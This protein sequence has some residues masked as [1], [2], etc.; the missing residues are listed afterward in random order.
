MG[1]RI[2][3]E[4]SRLMACLVASFVTLLLPDTAIAGQPETAPV[5][6]QRLPAWEPGTLDIHHIDT[7]VGNA[8]FVMA[9]DGT[10]M[11]I[12]CGA[13]RGGPPAST[14]LRP[15]ESRSVGAWVS[16]YVLR[17]A[18]PAN[19]STLDYI[20]AT[21]VHPD[22][23]GSPIAGDPVSADGYVLTG[24]SEVDSLVPSRT[25]IDR[26]FPLYGPIG[27]INAPFASNHLAWLQSR[28]KSGKAVEAVKVGS[29]TQLRPRTNGSFVARFIAGNGRVWTGQGEQSKDLLAPA[30]TWTEESRPDEN[31][32]SI[33]LLLE[34]GGFRYFTGG[35][36]AADTHDGAFPWLDIETPVAAAAGHV[37]VATA[38]HHGYFDANWAGFVRELD[39]DAYVVQGW[40]ATHP[41]PASL[42]RLLNAWRGR[43]TKDVFVTRLDAA[44]EAVNGR[45][46]SQLKSRQGNVVVRVHADGSYRVF[47]TDSRDE[48]DVLTYVGPLRRARS[49]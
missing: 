21:H 48:R 27:T 29:A 7:G 23:V 30:S 38:N 46:L 37:D 13:T 28:L 35:D 17:Q 22:H 41:A 3:R 39:A 42:Q 1:I 40:H 8:T 19:R 4:R 10:T 2:E 47:V 20:I 18:R 45:F 26:G 34:Y 36:L 31:A 32:M 25:V 43:I 15:N 16:R 12:D 6:G 14:G 49:R 33:A 11:L 5:V 44:S 24:L 9:P